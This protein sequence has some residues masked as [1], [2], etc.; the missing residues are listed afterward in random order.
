MRATRKMRHTAIS[1]TDS[2]RAANNAGETADYADSR[3]WDF[4]R[5][6]RD[7]KRSSSSAERSLPGLTL[8]KV[9]LE[10]I[11]VHLRNLRLKMPCLTHP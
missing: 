5:R 8:A 11:C 3:R 7:L 10:K 9:C 1:A 4:R 6:G 2:F